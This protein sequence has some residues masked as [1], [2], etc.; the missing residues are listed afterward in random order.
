MCCVAFAD[1]GSVV[2]PSKMNSGLCLERGKEPFLNL[3]PFKWLLL[4]SLL[5]LGLDD[6]KTY[7]LKVENCELQA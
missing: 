6:C 2:M 3:W 1:V 5:L 7:S 4:L